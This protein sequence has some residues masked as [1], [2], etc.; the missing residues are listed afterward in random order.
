[1]TNIS[2]TV[3][4]YSAGIVEGIVESV[5]LT[6]RPLSVTVYQ[7]LS[8]LREDTAPSFGT[9][10]TSNSKMSTNISVNAHFL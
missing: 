10:M 5:V 8:V 4:V 1:M 6:L 9:T 3:K 2:G 7:K